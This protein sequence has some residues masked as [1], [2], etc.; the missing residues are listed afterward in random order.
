MKLFTVAQ[1]KRFFT[2]L[3]RMG[4]EVC[5]RYSDGN[6][7]PCEKEVFVRR[8]LNKWLRGKYVILYATSEQTNVEYKRYLSISN[9]KFAL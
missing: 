2:V 9:V 7:A 6:F 4:R 3:D 5:N 8:T 1:V